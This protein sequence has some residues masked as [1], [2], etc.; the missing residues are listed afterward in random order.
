[1]KC[2]DALPCAR[3]HSTALPRLLLTQMERDPLLH[4]STGLSV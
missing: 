2:F 3:H 4:H 1:M